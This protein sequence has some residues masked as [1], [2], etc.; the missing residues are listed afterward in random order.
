MSSFSFLK[1]PIPP[2]TSSPAWNFDFIVLCTFISHMNALRRRLS[3]KSG[4]PQ[5]QATQTTSPQA[6]CIEHPLSAVSSTPAAVLP[7]PP[8]A[9]ERRF[10]TKTQRG[11][12]APQFNETF[13]TEGLLGSFLS[14]P[15]QVKVLDYDAVSFDDT[16]GTLELSLEALREHD[17]LEL[18]KC[19]LSGVAHGTLSMVVLWTASGAAAGDT[20]R[21]EQSGSLS[22]RVVEAAE[23]IAADR[24]GSSDPYVIVQLAGGTASVGSA[25]AGGFD[26][27]KQSLE[28]K[29]DSVA[30]AI[31]PKERPQVPMERVD[32]PTPE[33]LWFTPRGGWPVIPAHGRKLSRPGEDATPT[34]TPTAAAAATTTTTTPPTVRE[35]PPPLLMPTAAE[36]APLYEHEEGALGELRVEVLQA[37]GLKGTNLSKLNLRGV[38]ATSD[39]YALLM[40]EGFAART[41]TVAAND[42]PP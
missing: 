1:R 32:A 2:N 4:D 42:A 28:E 7:P 27:A 39:P 13:V 35:P 37:E 14:G 8:K 34:A 36:A 18:T 15:L 30:A 25:L 9:T 22:V 19:K 17:Q 21:D 20:P 16:L 5:R 6:A 33:A 23:L 41:S 29:L 31:K 11:S 10:R 24:S 12:L 38:G 40:V 3:T 26:R